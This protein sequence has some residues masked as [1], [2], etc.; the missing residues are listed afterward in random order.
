ML[1]FILLVQNPEN[2]RMLPSYK[3]GNFLERSITSALVR[4]SLGA[5]NAKVILKYD[6]ASREILS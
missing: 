2:I 4:L 6:F 1:S 3:K 5:L